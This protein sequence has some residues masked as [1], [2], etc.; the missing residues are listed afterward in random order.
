VEEGILDIELMNRP[1]PGERKGEDGPN[2]GEFD[3]GAE[4]LVVV[5]FGPCSGRVSHPRSACGGKFT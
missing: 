2:G 4:G 3:D 5:H 1:V